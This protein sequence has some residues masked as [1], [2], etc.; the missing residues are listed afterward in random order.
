MPIILSTCHWSRIKLK[1]WILQGFP[2]LLGEKQ[3]HH[4]GDGFATWIC[5]PLCKSKTNGTQP[6]KF[7]ADET[8]FVAKCHLAYFAR[9]TWPVLFL[10]Y[11]SENYR[12]NLNISQS[13]CKVTTDQFL[14]LRKRS[15]SP[16]CMSCFFVFWFLTCL[17]CVHTTNFYSL[18]FWRITGF[19]S[20]ISK[21]LTPR[22]IF[23]PGFL[24]S[25]NRHAIAI[26]DTVS[27]TE[28]YA[29][30]QIHYFFIVWV[31]GNWVAITK[32]IYM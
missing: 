24:L 32:I 14:N 16:H 25:L 18:L 17:F 8:S 26:P 15:L 2:L 22:S 20:V 13:W 11:A 9:W 3:F 19:T 7:W 23:S 30:C 4:F 27:N 29:L 21:L 28:N 31:I 10:I 6:W 12:Q 5:M 1:V